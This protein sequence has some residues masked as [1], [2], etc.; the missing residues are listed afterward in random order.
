MQKGLKT[1]QRCTSANTILNKNGS[2]V[3]KIE[4]NRSPKIPT[5]KLKT[6]HT[7]KSQS[8]CTKC[9]KLNTQKKKDGYDTIMKQMQLKK[10]RI[11]DDLNKMEGVKSPKSLCKENKLKYQISVLKAEILNEQ[12]KKKKLSCDLEKIQNRY[13]LN[14]FHPEKK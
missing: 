6:T 9:K 13:K 11:L 3:I 7:K 8:K 2:T 14:N 4:K 1:T 5:E 10:V 12:D